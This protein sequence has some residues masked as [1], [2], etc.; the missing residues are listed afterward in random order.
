MT[1]FLSILLA[2]LFLMMPPSP[3]SYLAIDVERARVRYPAPMPG[4]LRDDATVIAIKRDGKVFLG[5]D[6]A[7]LDN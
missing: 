3:H 6:E 4:A 5:H 1:A 2:L 7:R